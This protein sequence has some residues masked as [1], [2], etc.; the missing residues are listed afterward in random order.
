MAKCFPSV[1]K[2]SYSV[3]GQVFSICQKDV[4]WRPWPIDVHW[5]FPFVRKTSYDAHGEVFPI[6][7]KDVT[8]RPARSLA[9]HACSEETKFQKMNVSGWPKPSANL[10]F[11][12]NHISIKNSLAGPGLV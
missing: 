12:K 6:H 9:D 1:R 11:G 7:E 5:C 4:I 2:P 8:G 10:F 3:H